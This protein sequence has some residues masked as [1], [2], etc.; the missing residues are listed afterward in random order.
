L[1]KHFV[2]EYRREESH[3]FSVGSQQ[4]ELRTPAGQF[5]DLAQKIFGE[6]RQRLC[7]DQ[8]EHLLHLNAVDEQGRVAAVAEAFAV[9]GHVLAVV[10]YRGFRGDASNF[11]VPLMRCGRA[12]Y[13][14]CLVP[15]LLEDCTPRIDRFPY[16]WRFAG[17]VVR[18][19]VVLG[20]NTVR[21][22]AKGKN[23]QS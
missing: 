2:F 4:P 10:L 3:Q 16:T 8:P 22:P 15:N 7:R 14:V 19:S 21:R 23:A 17:S 18:S 5:V 13:G 11:H 1:T 12:V 20:R 6:G 9:S